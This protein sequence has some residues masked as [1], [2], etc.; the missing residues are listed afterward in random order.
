MG[1]ILIRRLTH[2]LLEQAREML[3]VFKAHLKGNFIDSFIGI[4]NAV[5][6]HVDGLVLDI[7]FGG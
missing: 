1:T 3:W 2:A 6:C 5:F 4:E 7:I